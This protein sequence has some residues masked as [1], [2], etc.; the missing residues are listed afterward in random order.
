MKRLLLLA[1]M[2]MLVGATT[3]QAIPV[4]DVQYLREGDTGY[5]SALVYSPPSAQGCGAR[6]IVQIFRISNR[7]TY[8]TRRG[9]VNVCRSQSG[10]WT[11]GAV[12]VSFY[13]LRWPVA[14]YMVCVGAAQRL[15]SGADSRHAT[16]VRRRI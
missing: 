3:A 1:V 10:A 4:R 2:A 8:L 12:T 16:C 14:D 13:L 7:A 15:A 9:N 11:V 5:A 6:Y